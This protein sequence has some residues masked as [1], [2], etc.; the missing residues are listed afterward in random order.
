MKRR[1]SRSQSWQAPPRAT[2]PAS[3]RSRG[4]LSIWLQVQPLL[5]RSRVV[6]YQVGRTARQRPGTL[7]PEARAGRSVIRPT[8]THWFPWAANI[9]K[10]T[11]RYAWPI[12]CGLLDCR[13][14]FGSAGMGSSMRTICCLAG[15]LGHPS[16]WQATQRRPCSSLRQDQV[17]ARNNT[18]TQIRNLI[19]NLLG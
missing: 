11:T 12:S 17:D 7:P 8:S 2:A 10:P 5:H 19:P 18:R 9:H 13:W 16:R 3:R 15:S 6:G 1:S 4:S 14:F